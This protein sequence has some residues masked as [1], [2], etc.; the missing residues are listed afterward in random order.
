MLDNDTFTGNKTGYLLTCL[1]N[2]PKFK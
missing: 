2:Y 1:Q